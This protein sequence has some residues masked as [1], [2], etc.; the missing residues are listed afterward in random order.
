VAS[1]AHYTPQCQLCA[2]CTHTEV[3]SH[4]AGRSS[5]VR[6]ATDCHTQYTIRARGPDPSYRTVRIELR[7]DD[8]KRARALDRYAQVSLRNVH[9]GWFAA[10]GHVRRLRV[11]DGGPASTRRSIDNGHPPSKMEAALQ[12]SLQVTTADCA[13]FLTR[14]GP[15]NWRSE[16][17]RASLCEIFR[18]MDS[19]PFTSEQIEYRPVR[20]CPHGFATP[21]GLV[22]GVAVCARTGV[23][24]GPVRALQGPCRV[25]RLTPVLLNLPDDLVQMLGRRVQV[26]G[27]GGKAPVAFVS[28]RSQRG[29]RRF[30]PCAVHQTTPA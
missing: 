5:E 3:G 4:A 22:G 18:S 28:W 20:F 21:P 8:A 29:G 1:A 15:R 16:F 17:R 12:R 23:R 30:E 10:C 19:L 26:P 13:P 6:K 7:S 11:P 27:H 9:P 2:S 14:A 25:S 24:L